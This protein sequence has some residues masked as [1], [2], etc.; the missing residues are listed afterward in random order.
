MF[1]L[2]PRRLLV[3][4][5][6][7]LSACVGGP[8]PADIS[9]VS[10][11]LSDRVGAGLGPGDDSWPD[12]V[13][14]GDGVTEDEA[15][16]VALWRSPEFQ[17]AICALGLAR[18]ELM[19]AEIIP[20][21]VLSLL[22]P[23][24]PKQLEYTLKWP[25]DV[26]W[27]RPKRIAAARL[28][29]D[30]AAQ[31]LVQGGLDLV[32]DVRSSYAD[33]RRVR[34]L[35]LDANALT[36]LRQRRT[37]VERVRVRA[38]DASP[39]EAA[40]ADGEAKIAAAQAQRAQVEVDLATAR[41]ATIVGLADDGPRVCF[42]DDADRGDARTASAAELAHEAL[43]ARPDLRAAELAIEAA[44]ER[45]GLAERQAL[46]LTAVLDASPR[47]NSNELNSGPG[48]ELPLPLFD[49]NQPGKARAA[50]DLERATKHYAVVRHRISY[51]VRQ[52]YAE[53]AS[54]Q[55][56]LAAFEREVIPALQAAERAARV[57]HDAGATSPLPVLDAQESVLR[58]RSDLAQFAFARD[59]AR[60]QLE[61]SVGRTL[62]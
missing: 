56:A 40:R 20:N 32:R 1:E 46:A 11:A 50:T 14:L 23:I 31:L 51:E 21:P 55:H 8:N 42:V 7:W 47:D 54:T 49:R 12:T 37:E 52:A 6:A 58:A 19:R 16:A 10:E 33:L 45:A 59:R 44:V 26:L 41:L 28:D 9:Q 5:L 13:V 18:A 35:A 24:G 4:A 57:A 38:G 60:A 17:E 25:V 39:H 2:S 34:R 61:R 22:F 53:L 15:V 30:H 27:L 43:A 62:E 36:T 48:I 3:V 29:T